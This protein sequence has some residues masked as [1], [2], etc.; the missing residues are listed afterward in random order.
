MQEQFNQIQDLCDVRLWVP[1]VRLLKWSKADYAFTFGTRRLY[2]GMTDRRLPFNLGRKQR[3]EQGSTLACAV[4]KAYLHRMELLVSGLQ[5]SLPD[6]EIAFLGRNDCARRGILL[7]GQVVFVFPAWLKCEGQPFNP[8]TVRR[9]MFG[10]IKLR[11]QTDVMQTVLLAHSELQA[12]EACRL[13]AGNDITGC[14]E[15]RACF[16]YSALSFAYAESEIEPDAFR[17]SSFRR[18]AS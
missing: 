17:A 9:Y 2:V 4:L 5:V 11:I 18:R 12:G 3:I 7:H 14:H 15:P 1:T 8:V 10:R 16:S 6:R 13:W